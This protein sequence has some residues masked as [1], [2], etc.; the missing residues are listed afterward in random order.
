MVLLQLSQSQ[1]TLIEQCPRKFQYI[2]LDQL[3]TPLQ[4]EQ[5]E[6]LTRGS[7]VHHLMQ[8]HELQLPQHTLHRL[9]NN[10]ETSRSPITHT[11]PFNPQPDQIYPMVQAL[12]SAVPPRD[13][14]TVFRQSEY[15][16]TLDWSDVLL[17]VI[18]DL[19]LLDSDHAHIFDWKTYLRP[20][21]LQHLRQR[22]AQHWQTKLYPFV[23]VATSAYPPEAV[24]I[25]YWFV[26]RNLHSLADDEE[27]ASP[28]QQPIYQKDADNPFEPECLTFAY[29]DR[30]HQ[31]TKQDL[32]QIITQLQ[33]WLDDYRR[34]QPLP[35][36]DIAQGLCSSCSF[37][38]RCDRM[39]DLTAQENWDH[40][41]DITTIPEIQPLPRD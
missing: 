24:D 33:H 34:N 29:S 15:R 27:Q 18:Y 12:I 4:A 14:T 20:P 37:R 39:D 13:E 38:M 28:D 1:L 41:G 40:L 9:N 16:L 11:T 26:K 10:L 25:S 19:L 30:L 6:H 7:Q 2:Y 22:L 36:V 23:L 35:K 17:T 5:S 3:T 32:T 31:Q 21:N 8:Q